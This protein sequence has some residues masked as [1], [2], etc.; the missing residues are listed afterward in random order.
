MKAFITLALILISFSAFSHEGSTE[1]SSF[2]NQDEACTWAKEKVSSVA[3]REKL[4][5][6]EIAE[7]CTCEVDNLLTVC[8]VNFTY[9]Y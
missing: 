3:I 8:S 1:A 9:E 4:S 6:T 2:N 5:I 7:A